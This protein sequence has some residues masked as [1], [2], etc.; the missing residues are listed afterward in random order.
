MK[1]V[2]VSVD[3][4]A[5]IAT[6]IF[7]GNREYKLTDKNF[8]IRALPAILENARFT[9]YYSGHKKGDRTPYVDSVFGGDVPCSFTYHF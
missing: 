2:K 7:D 3:H 5:R 9:K 6:V 1:T 4:E 8:G